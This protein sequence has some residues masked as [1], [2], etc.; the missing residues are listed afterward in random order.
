M[1]NEKIFA[2]EKINDMELDRVSGG[3]IAEVQDII[4]KMEQCSGGVGVVSDA[5]RFIVNRLPKHRGVGKAALNIVYKGGAKA[6]LA[7]LGIENDLSVGVCGTGAFESKNSYSLNGKKLT[8]AE[9]LAMI[10]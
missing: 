6:A 8:H 4:R 2:N 1:T 10:K 9:V 3:T 7:F 5:C